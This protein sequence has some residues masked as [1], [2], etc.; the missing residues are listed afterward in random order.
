M[1][2]IVILLDSL[3]RHFL[4]CYGND[5]VI[6][7]NIARLAEK[8]VVFDR[9]FCGSMPC[10]PARREMF[11]GRYNFLESP[12]GALEP[13]DD[14]LPMMLRKQADVYTHMITDH[15]HYF[16]T[17]GANYYTQFQT[18]E[19]CRGQESDEWIPRVAEP[20]IPDFR[21]R[22]KRQ[23]WVNRTVMDPQNDL[24]YPTP[25][26]FQKAVEFLDANGHEDNWHLHLE[27]FD[28]HEPFLCPD[29]YRQMYDDTWDHSKFHY[30]WPNYAPVGSDGEEADAVEHIR[31][32]YAG[33]LTMAD[34]WLG[35][36]LDK[37]DQMDLWKDTT[38]ILTTDHGHMLG[39]HNYWAKNYMYVYR[40]LAN[41]PMIVA[42]PEAQAGQRRNALTA[43][44][45]LVP[46]VLDLHGLEPTE[47]M[48]GENFRPLLSQDG[49]GHDAVLYGYF[50]KDI[51]MTDGRYT[52]TRQPE[53]NSRVWHYTTLPVQ[54]YHGLDH[55][56]EATFCDN[57]PFS[58]GVAMY[59]IP[60]WSH[61]HRDAPDRNP[62]IFD[63][64][65]D[66]GQS[67]PLDDPALEEKLTDKLMEVLRRVQAPACQY[68]RTGLRTPPGAP[69]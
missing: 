36:L 13:I 17:N 2:T 55:L 24:D 38:V 6:A 51:N 43:T 69:G 35:K 64:E 50:G 9:H 37:M 47:R 12:W 42:S 5:W 3:N 4:P 58:Q 67:T 18:Y 45:D 68:E 46:T 32:S 15:Y 31:K 59:K 54:H 34:A 52:Y 57:L 7:P 11:T 1:K 62:I 61:R 41:I 66:P 49:P 53:E 27:C 33:T 26:C 25:Q 22:N 40:E 14:N 48:E 56:R 39:E 16:E 23:N 65:D 8:G 21:G 63:L 44:I 30:D 19:F 10:M 29:R 28:P 20:D 60:Q